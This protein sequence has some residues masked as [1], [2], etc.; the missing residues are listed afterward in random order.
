MSGFRFLASA[1]RTDQPIV[2]VL[3]VPL[4][5]LLWW[6]QV[7]YP[8]PVDMIGGMPLYHGL[9]ALTAPWPWLQG[10]LGVLCAGGTAPLLASTANNSEL[11]GKRTRLPALLLLLLLGLVPGPL[12]NAAMLACPLVLFAL[13]KGWALQG[14]ANV[15]GQLLLA[16]LL[17]GSAALFYLPF[18]FVG[19]ALWAA[20][21]VMRPFNW[22]EYAMPVV[23]AAVA[24]YFCWGVM[25]LAGMP[26][27]HPVD[28]ITQAAHPALPNG[29]LLVLLVLVLVPLVTISVVGFLRSYATGIMRERN[30]RSA[31][32]ALCWSLLA[33]IALE[34][35][36]H[37]TFPLALL[38]LPLA[39]LCT[40]PM[41]SAQR[42]WPMELAA[43]AL[44]ALGCAA[45]WS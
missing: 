17:T 39:V 16:G 37:R 10:L 30:S 38:T 15:F 26:G 24:F 43:S 18:I 41:L 35:L 29:K 2:L 25:H 42:T 14:R 22:R 7:A 20:I 3:L 27:V 21:S 9:A 5:V 19:A 6:R 31:F 1:F 8:P 34:V 32:L 12:F 33:M 36:L 40:Y 11:F 13:R 23:G 45:Q 4:L 28:S 44:L